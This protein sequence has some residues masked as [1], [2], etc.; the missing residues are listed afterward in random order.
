MK[1]TL[2]I[3]CIGAAILGGY[4]AA[5]QEAA[6]DAGPQ[7][8]GTPRQHSDHELG[9][10]IYARTC[11]VCHGEQGNAASWA[12][13]SLNPPPRDFTS[14]AGRRLSRE[15]MLSAV[16]YGSP[17]TAMMPFT[18]QFSP[19]ELEAV[20]DYVRSAFMG[21]GSETAAP[22]GLASAP[23][24]G[25]G[26]SGGHDHGQAMGGNMDM[27][28]SFPAG[29]AGHFDRGRAIYNDN[30]ATCHGLQGD[31]TG[32]RAYFL[33]R[34]PRD[35][36][37]NRASAELNRPHLFEAIAKGVRQTEMAAWSKVLSA[38]EIADVGEYV[39]STFIHSDVPEPVSGA[40]DAT[41]G[42]L[43]KN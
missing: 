6:A 8:A 5:A 17:G 37:S 41:P 3:L 16:T 11:S 30:C 43:K 14:A 12:K 29:L 7:D 26:H 28:A 36:T 20:V 22:A 15:R 42:V 13:N 39:F 18:S 34:K 32:P 10:R 4:A 23:A 31:G 2:A 9:E 25:H 33:S 1:K 35:F 38:Q 24:G 21:A 40:P 19:E 27:A